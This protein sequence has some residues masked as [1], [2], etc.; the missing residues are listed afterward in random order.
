MLFAKRVLQTC[1]M[2]RIARIRYEFG[3]FFEMIRPKHILIRIGGKLWRKQICVIFGCVAKGQFCRRFNAIF[4]LNFKQNPP[5][6]PLFQVLSIVSCYLC[7][8]VINNKTVFRA[9]FLC[10]AWGMLE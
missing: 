9:L 6:S 1:H 7:V 3:G 2:I 4:S 10:F 5:I 8:P